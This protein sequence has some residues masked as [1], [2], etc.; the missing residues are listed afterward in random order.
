MRNK[1]LKRFYAKSFLSDTNFD[2]NDSIDHSL[3]SKEE[4][5]ARQKIYE[6][7]LKS[8]D[9]YNKTFA[10]NTLIA[11]CMEALNALS[12]QDNAKVYAEG[13]F[14][15]TKILEPIVPH[16]CNVIMST[17]IKY[18]GMPLINAL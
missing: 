18:I 14:V 10:F 2:I 5:L 9:V 12:S 17:C 13:Y 8:E 4:K 3:L 1:F 6:A 15:L 11:S 16:I 7:F